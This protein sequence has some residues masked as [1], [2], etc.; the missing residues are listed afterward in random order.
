MPFQLTE[1]QIAS[2][3]EQGY[4]ILRAQEHGLIENPADLK[5]WSEQVKS[6]PR[7]KGMWMP[8]DEK[9][10]KG[11]RILMRTENFVDYHPEFTKLLH[12]DGLREILG[13]LNGDVNFHITTELVNQ[14]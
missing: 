3:N 10:S 5:V 4:L 8:Y 2:Y 6:W 7:V 14:S 13:K 1:E 12:G 9:S 11:E